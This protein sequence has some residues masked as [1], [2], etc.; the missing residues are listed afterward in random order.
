MYQVTNGP[1]INKA[2]LMQTDPVELELN[3]IKQRVTDS[4]S[5]RRAT[6]MFNSKLDVHR[7]YLTVEVPE[8]AWKAFSR[9]RLGSHWLKVETG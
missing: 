3:I 2:Q 8:F 4:V 1:L 6:Y 9:I 7:M 5:S